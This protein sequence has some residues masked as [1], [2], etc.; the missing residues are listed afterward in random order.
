MMDQ[1]EKKE[2]TM[3][4]YKIWIGFSLFELIVLGYNDY[5]IESTK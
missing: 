5:E 2:E 1:L 3:E 4:D